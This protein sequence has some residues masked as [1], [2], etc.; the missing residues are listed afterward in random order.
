MVQSYWD[1][2]PFP[3]LCLVPLWKD[4][5]VRLKRTGLDDSFVPG[6]HKQRLNT[7]TQQLLTV[8]RRKQLIIAT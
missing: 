3:D 2:D 1:T 7:Y 4:V 6:G 5:D 8:A